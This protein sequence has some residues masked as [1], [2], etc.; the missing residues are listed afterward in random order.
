MPVP[1]SNQTQSP[2]R[3][4]AGAI[5]LAC[6]VAAFAMLG[7]AFASKPLYDT[8]CRVTGF[9]GETRVASDAA[10]VTLA[11]E[12]SVRF[13]SNVEPGLPFRF[14]PVEVARPLRLGES[15]LAFYRVTNLSDQ[16]VRAVATYNVT[17]HK[18][19]P[20]FAKLEC[21]CFQEQDFAPGETLDL[22]VVFFV[23]PALH[24]D[25]ALDDVRAITLSYT[26]FQ[27]SGPQSEGAEA[28]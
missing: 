20:Y 11:R 23:D 15:A 6:S 22:P 9:G 25:R 1:S 24:D 18:A 28:T 12:V 21:F 4:N 2:R 16:T 13:D 14:E 3:A 10:P 17:P 7:L 26:F 8:F 27:A 5:A 19:G